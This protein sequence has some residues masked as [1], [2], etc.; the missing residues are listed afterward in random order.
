MRKMRK[1]IG[2]R[3]ALR[4]WVLKTNSTMPAT[5]RGREAT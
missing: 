5:K 1:A 4:V 3:R 2:K